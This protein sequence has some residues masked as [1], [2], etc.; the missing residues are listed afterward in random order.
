[1]KFVEEKMK[2]M[3]GCRRKDRISNMVDRAVV[4]QPLMG[5]ILFRHQ[6]KLRT[7]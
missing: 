6:N 4:A 2:K 7:I 1:M 5:Q 3:N